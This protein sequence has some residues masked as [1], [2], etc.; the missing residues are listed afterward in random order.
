MINCYLH[1]TCIEMYRY[2][3]SL[4]VVIHILHSQPEQSV[5]YHPSLTFTGDSALVNEL[6][7]LRM[8]LKYAHFR[9]N[10]MCENQHGSMD[11]F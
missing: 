9:E 2:R 1:V 5:S 8:K 7:R 4:V 3:H 6:C 10:I 11:V